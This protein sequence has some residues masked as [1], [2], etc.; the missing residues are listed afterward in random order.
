MLVATSDLPT[1]PLP[2]PTAIRRRPIEGRSSMGGSR[3]ELSGSSR[4]SSSTWSA[5]VAFRS[6][7][8][9]GSAGT[10]SPLRSIASAG[11]HERVDH[12]AD[13]LRARAGHYQER[14]VGLDH[15][16]VLDA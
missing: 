9:G 7:G 13:V 12:R 16:E 5:N 6:G 15:H 8:G 2:P 11:S 4:A 1:P 14:I 10:A 3:D